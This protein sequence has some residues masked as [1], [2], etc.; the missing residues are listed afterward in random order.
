MADE[1]DKKICYMVSIPFSNEELVKEVVKRIK[2]MFG[3]ASWIEKRNDTCFHYI[4]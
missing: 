3:Y 4:K 1:T 2:G